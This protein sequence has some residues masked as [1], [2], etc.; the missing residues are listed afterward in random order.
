M[1]T[2]RFP[3]TLLEAFGTD[4]RSAC[5]IERPE[6]RAYGLAWWVCMCLIAV[7]TLAL[8]WSGA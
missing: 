4:A 8:C 5:A 1:N 6:G 3:R 2:R 7:T